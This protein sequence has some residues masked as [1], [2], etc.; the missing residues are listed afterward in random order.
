MQ[1]AASGTAANAPATPPKRAPD[2]TTI[3]TVAGC[4]GTFFPIT[5]L[6]QWAQHLAQLNPL[7]H[8]VELVRHA[9]FGFAGATDLVHVAA[10]LIFGV[11]T[12][13]VA[14]WRMSARLIL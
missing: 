2:A 10:L 5:G 1:T 3:S 8:T 11:A 7:Y 4:N 9:A 12:W 14:I 13:R 6:P